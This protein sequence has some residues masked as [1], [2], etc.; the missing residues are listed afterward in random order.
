MTLVFFTFTTSEAISY[1]GVYRFKIPS[2][3]F[4]K[5][6]P[7][8]YRSTHL[9]T[10]RGLKQ[11]IYL[12]I[13]LFYICQFYF[14]FA[15]LCFQYHSIPYI[16]WADGCMASLLPFMVA[17]L[18][19]NILLVTSTTKVVDVGHPFEWIV[20]EFVHFLF[21]QYCRKQ[22]LWAMDQLRRLTITLKL[23]KNRGSF[24]LLLKYVTAV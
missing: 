2:I 19:Q 22:L 5:L 15:K 6:L 23:A 20:A 13:Y 11:Q 18:C 7:R 21:I 14:T 9:P 24:F 1:P 10:R 17:F 3:P 12:R 4:T 8:K 16:P